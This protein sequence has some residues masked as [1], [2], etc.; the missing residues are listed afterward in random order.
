MTKTLL[1]TG[2]GGGLGRHLV[3]VGLQAG[4]NVLATDLT[5]DVLP[6][7]DQQQDRLRVLAVDVTS[8]ADARTAVQYA[9]SE[10]GRLD[11]LV[12]S[13]GYRSVGSIEDMPEDEFRR[14]VEI[15]FFGAV[16][17]VRAALPVLRPQR[18]GSIVNVSTIGGRR[19]QAGLAAYQAAK[20]ALGGFTEIL[21][22]EVETIGIHATLV[23]PGGIRTPWAAA[24]MSVPP[25]QDEYDETVGAF[26]R[27]YR[28]NQDVQRG[29]PAKMARVILRITEEPQPP[30]RLLLGSD[31]AWLAPLIAEARATEDAAWRE[32]SQSTD[33]DGLGDFAETSVAKMVRPPTF[34]IS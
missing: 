19:A 22:R 34:P 7:P 16:N 14:T 15:N 12:N 30:V 6:V 24:P 27:T 29:D 31:A 26:V 20:W 8:S 18:S 10:F 9:V 33:L 32:V 3:D 17:M 1:V 2:A 23:E 5:T 25:M 13:A 4:H 11:V 28:D 21:A